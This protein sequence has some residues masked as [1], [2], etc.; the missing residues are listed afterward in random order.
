MAINTYGIKMKGLK[1]ASGCTENYGPYSG[2]YVELFYNKNSGDIWGTFQ[3]SLGQNSWT[4][5]H[6]PDIIKICNTSSHMT[7]QQIADRIRDR[8]QDAANA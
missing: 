6:D 8:L 3:H 2:S 5:Y 1:K 4:V 7:M